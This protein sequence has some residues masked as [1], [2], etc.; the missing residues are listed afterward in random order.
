MMIAVA[1]AVVTAHRGPAPRDLGG[2][3]GGTRLPERARDL[4]EA[5]AHR[6]VQPTQDRL[7]AVAAAFL[8]VG[9]MR[10]VP[11]VMAVRV[12]MVVAAALR[13]TV[14]VGAALVGA[15]GHRADL[16]AH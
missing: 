2:G 13:M 10:V 14:I 11:L 6:I 3:K 1:L 16:P 12:S 4:L 9:I 8:L 15:P 7:I 5:E